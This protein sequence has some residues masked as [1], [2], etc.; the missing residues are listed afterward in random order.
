MAE[1]LSQVFSCEFCE[2]SRSTF[3][4]YTEHV[5]GGDCFYIFTSLDT[6][7]FRFLKYMC[8]SHS[9]NTVYKICYESC[10]YNLSGKVFALPFFS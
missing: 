9:K 1:T 4:F 7:P 2:I 3:T 6:A 8:K 5:L 10:K